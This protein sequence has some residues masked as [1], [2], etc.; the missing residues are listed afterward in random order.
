MIFQAA[1]LLLVNRVT[2]HDMK[3]MMAVAADGAAGADGAVH[4]GAAG[5]QGADA[6]DGG[7]GGVAADVGVLQAGGAVH[8]DRV[9][10]DLVPGFDALGG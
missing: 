5:L 9:G 7:A 10:G 1:N 6:A 3:V 4:P 2:I 8:P